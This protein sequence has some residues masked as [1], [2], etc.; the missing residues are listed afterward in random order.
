MHSAIHKEV[1]GLEE[2]LLPSERRGEIFVSERL[3][4]ASSFGRTV[5][6]L[7][8]TLPAPLVRVAWR[9]SEQNWESH[10][11]GSQRSHHWPRA[12]NRRKRRHAWYK[13]EAHLQLI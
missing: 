9:T 6:H 2:A 10:R 13:Q 3:S 8:F 5:C 4:Q 11:A 7:R 1:A 12:Q